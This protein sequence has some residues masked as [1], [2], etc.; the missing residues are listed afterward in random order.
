MVTKMPEK[1]VSDMKKIISVKIDRDICLD[2]QVC[3]HECPEVFGVSIDGDPV[4]KSDAHKYYQTHQQRIEY[5]A[6]EI[7]PFGAIRVEYD[8]NK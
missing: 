7:C 6:R 4:V 5:V 3:I 1:C 2:H 8:K